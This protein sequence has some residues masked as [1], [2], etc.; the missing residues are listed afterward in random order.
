[1]FPRWVVFSPSR[2]PPPARNPKLHLPPVA[3]VPFPPTRTAPDK[4]LLHSEDSYI[5]NPGSRGCH[6]LRRGARRVSRLG[7]APAA[8][9][10]GVPEHELRNG[11]EME[12]GWDGRAW[13]VEGGGT[14]GGGGGDVGVS[15]GGGAGA[16][17]SNAVS[18]EESMDAAAKLSVPLKVM[19]F[20]DG[21]WLYY[22]FFGRFVAWYCRGAA[23]EA[24]SGVR[25]LAM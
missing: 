15:T 9:D 3:S 18:T 7:G 13:A 16:A 24:S 4:R 2:M 6:G 1:M 12:E 11:Y 5:H 14:A 10:N 22:S 25:P 20:I 19:V 8:A 21:T 17:S 23:A